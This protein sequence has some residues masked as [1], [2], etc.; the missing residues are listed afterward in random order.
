MKVLV[1]TTVW[2]DFFAGRT[3]PHVLKL[4]SFLKERQDLCTC[5]VILTEVLQGI[6]ADE[7]YSKTKA[8]LENLIFLPMQKATFEAAAEIYRSLRRRGITIRK[9]VDCLIAA[10]AIEH[11]IPVQ[12]ND[13]DFDPIV[14]H[15]GLKVI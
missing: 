15:C 6:R 12:H 1:D 5:G 7:D 13:R 9:P 14:K 10:V 4:E 11:G 3:V 8:L 2:I